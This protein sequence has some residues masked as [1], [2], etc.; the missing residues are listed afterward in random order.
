[1]KKTFK[2]FIKSNKVLS[3][4]ILPIFNVRSRNRNKNRIAF[5]KIFSNI[6]EGSLTVT[7]ENIPG[8]FEIDARSHIL[9][10]IL[11]KKDY[12]PEIVNH[13][14]TNINPTKDAINIGSNIGLFT[15]L[16]ANNINNNCKVLA[17]EPTPNAYKYLRRNIE[18]N[19]NNSKTIAYNGIASDKV[20]TY[21][22]NVIKGNEEY[23]S[24]G[25]IIHSATKGKQYNKIEVIGD[26][27]DNLINKYNL[28]P[29][30]IVIDVEGAENHVLNGAIE[31]LKKYHPIIISELD[32]SLLTNQ[33]SSSVQVIKLLNDLNYEVIDSENHVP[34]YPFSGNII[35]RWKKTIKQ[36]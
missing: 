18:R 9:K 27:V 36:N 29:G 13:I 34:V 17:I 25:D 16:L 8:E 35:A 14:L 22:L 5:E 10:R 6:V 19:G 20:G 1:M 4:V 23:S 33:N 21:S 2:K 32:D 7:V 24:L 28:N 12:E 3:S 26:T 15:N 30:I 31:T 11:L